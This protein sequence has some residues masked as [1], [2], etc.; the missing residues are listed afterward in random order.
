MTVCIV[1]AMFVCIAVISA[2]VKT[3]CYSWISVLELIPDM[4]SLLHCCA[5]TRKPILGNVKI[6]LIYRQHTIILYFTHGWQVCTVIGDKTR[7][8][9]FVHFLVAKLIIQPMEEKHKLR[10]SSTKWKIHISNDLGMGECEIALVLI[11]LHKF[12]SIKRVEFCVCVQN[13]AQSPDTHTPESH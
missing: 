10:W 12:Y 7:N 3:Q 8:T 11:M 2:S 5:D 4:K 9:K 6:I 1:T 13:I